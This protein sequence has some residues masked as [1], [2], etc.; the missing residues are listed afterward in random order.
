[1]TAPASKRISGLIPTLS[2]VLSCAK[3]EGQVLFPVVTLSGGL[4]LI[5]VSQRQ[6]PQQGFAKTG[7]GKSSSSTVN[8]HVQASL[9]SDTFLATGDGGKYDQ[10][11]LCAC[12]KTE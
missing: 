1:M 9:L 6:M 8:L 4:R 2:T 5:Y 7:F 11:T 3:A 10:N 12:M